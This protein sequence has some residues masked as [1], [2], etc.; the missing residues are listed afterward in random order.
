MKKYVYSGP[1]H[2]AEI[3]PI[4][5][6]IEKEDVDKTSKPIFSGWLANG[7]EVELPEDHPVIVAWV[8]R[9]WL[10]EPKA[11]DKAGDK[12]ADDKPA[13][14]KPATPPYTPPLATGAGGQTNL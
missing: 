1:P 10:S 4:S 3:C 11:D 2:A 13:A 7:S 9:G 8:A 5:A 6:S 12:P 14:P